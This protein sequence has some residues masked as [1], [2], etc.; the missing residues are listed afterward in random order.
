MRRA[1]GALVYVPKRRPDGVEWVQLASLHGRRG[2]NRRRLL[3]LRP[4]QGQLPLLLRPSSVSHRVLDR[5]ALSTPW[6]QLVVFD[7]GRFGPDGLRDLLQG[8]VVEL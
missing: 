8:A 3:G 5:A 6:P 4:S 2:D 7:D 1:S